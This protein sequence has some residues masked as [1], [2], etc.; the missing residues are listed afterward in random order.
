MIMRLRSIPEAAR[1]LGID[2][3]KLRRGVHAGRYAHYEIDGRILVD[4]DELAAAIE[5]EKRTIS[6]EEAAEL[7][8]L[9]KTMIR[10]G[11]RGGWLPCEKIGKAYRFTPARL[12]E[13]LEGR[14]KD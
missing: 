10:R 14:K 7:T 8:G 13:A 6:I 2:E 4:V 11:A 9:S 12:L 5:A 1:L 3:Q